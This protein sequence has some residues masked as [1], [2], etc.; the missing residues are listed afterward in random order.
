MSSLLGFGDTRYST[1]ENKLQDALE[2]LKAYLASEG[3]PGIYRPSRPYL[4]WDRGI[5]WTCMG[6]CGAVWLLWQIALKSGRLPLIPIRYQE[7]QTKTRLREWLTTNF[8]CKTEDVR[9]GRWWTM[10]LAAFSHIDFAHLVSNLSAFSSFSKY[11]MFVGIAPHRFVALILGS[12]LSG[13]LAATYHQALMEKQEHVQ[14]RSLGMSAVC[15][16]LIAAVAVLSPNATMSPMNLGRMPAWMAAF[17]YVLFD[18]YMIGSPTSMTGHP[19]HVGGAI[20]GAAY[21][22]IA[23]RGRL[24]LAE[25]LWK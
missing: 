6:T 5:M 14:R 7:T 10:V 2:S 18:T 19:A 12:A 17:S 1:D 21:S 8:T 25:W 13:S 3:V 23:L 24:P 20:F 16:G 22:C 9:R 15:M 11:L 4:I